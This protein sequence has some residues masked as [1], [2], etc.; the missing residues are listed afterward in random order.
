MLDAVGTTE[1]IG[2]TAGKDQAAGKATVVA[3]LGVDQ[4]RARAEAFA[5][6][7]VQHLQGFGPEADRLRALAAYVVD[8]GH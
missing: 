3:L 5:T 7:A 1:G 2:K 8:R 4:A 6:S